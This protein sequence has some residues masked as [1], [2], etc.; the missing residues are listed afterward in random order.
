MGRGL[1]HSSS[2]HSPAGQ[3]SVPSARNRKWGQWPAWACPLASITLPP[4][5]GHSLWKAVG[6]CQHP[7]PREQGPPTE[8]SSIIAQADLPWPPAQAGVL[9]SHDAVYRQ[10]PAAAVCRVRA[11]R[12]VEQ[13]RDPSYQRSGLALG[14]LRGHGLNLGSLRRMRFH[15]RQFRGIQPYSGQFK[16][17]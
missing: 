15:Q 3:D 16:R 10:L 12:A 2:K 6:S 5:S 8:V 9:A 4:Q 14:D 11:V 1:G 17:T 13:S 7:V